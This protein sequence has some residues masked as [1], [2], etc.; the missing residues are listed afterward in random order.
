MVVNNWWIYCIID[1]WLNLILS[2]QLWNFSS[3]IVL[4]YKFFFVFTDFQFLI[5]SFCFVTQFKHDHFHHPPW[6]FESLVRVRLLN[7]D[8]FTLNRWAHKNPIDGFL[9]VCVESLLGTRKQRFGLTWGAFWRSDL[10]VFS[11]TERSWA[12]DTTYKNNYLYHW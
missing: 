9:V 3:L 5:S 8:R 10:K 11:S 1:K 4:W 6:G 7:L 2:Y 12:Q